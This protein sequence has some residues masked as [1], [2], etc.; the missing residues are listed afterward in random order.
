MSNRNI[1]DIIYIFES[2]YYILY[3]YFVYLLDFITLNEYIFILK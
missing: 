1:I 2:K 3:K